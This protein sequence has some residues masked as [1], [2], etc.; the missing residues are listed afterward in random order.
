M[1]RGVTMADMGREFDDVLDECLE[2]LASGETIAECCA[3]YPGHAEDLAPLLRS[4]AAVRQTARVTPHLA[5]AR[6]RGYERL[7]QAL[8]QGTGAPKPRPT[9]WE[10]L[11]NLLRTP[12]ARPVLA[13]FAAILVVLFAAG[14]TTV[15]ARSSVPG[16]PLY[17]VKTTQENISLRMQRTDMDR[18]EQHARLANER[19]DEMHT[20]IER[21]NLNEA[22]NLIH[23]LRGHITQSAH[24]AGVVVVVNPVEMPNTIIVHLSARPQLTPL[25]T[26]MDLSEQQRHSRRP[27]TLQSAPSDQRLRA[28]IVIGRC[29]L[30]YGV[31]HTALNGDGGGR[32]LFRAVAGSSF[33]P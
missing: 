33:G 1:R 27:L 28:Q 26:L 23:R 13:A 12:V 30:W 2:R 32:L 25:R 15:A 20:L 29:E 9:L 7:A 21:G 18:S 31:F 6:A 8:A 22:E 10:R 11:G 24:Y 3:R 17:W 19:S 16:E 14:G 4:A 5:L